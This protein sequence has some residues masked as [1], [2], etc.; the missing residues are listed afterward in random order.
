MFALALLYF[1]WGERLLFARI[2]IC[3]VHLG[4]IYVRTLVYQEVC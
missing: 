2:G 1:S 3:T 4:L